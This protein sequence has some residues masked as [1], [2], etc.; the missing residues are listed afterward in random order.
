MRLVNLAGEKSENVVDID[1]KN[2]K[3]NEE[4]AMEKTDRVVGKVFLFHVP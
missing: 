3:L 1:L 2:F 4:D